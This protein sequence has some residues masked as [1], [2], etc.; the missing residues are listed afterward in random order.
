[1]ATTQVLPRNRTSIFHQPSWAPE[2]PNGLRN[3]SALF[4]ILHSSYRSI[5]RTIILLFFLF[6]CSISQ[7][8]VKAF[9][10]ATPYPYLFFTP[11]EV[12]QQKK[13]PLIIFLHG[14][15]WVKFDEFIQQ[16]IN[17]CGIPRASHGSLRLDQVTGEAE[18]FP[19]GVNGSVL[20]Q[21]FEI[22]AA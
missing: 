20:V 7:A 2:F 14:N 16:L 10:K 22:S 6:S 19:H 4:S 18:S 15:F 8:Q 21:L 12:N 11:S 3:R 5:L 17:F 13:L 9:P 1:M